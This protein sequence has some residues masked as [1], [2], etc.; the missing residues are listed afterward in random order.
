MDILDFTF[1]SKLRS[2][3]ADGVANQFKFKCVQDAGLQLYHKTATTLY[4]DASN[5]SIICARF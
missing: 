1:Y 3:T 2:H 4:V 5:S